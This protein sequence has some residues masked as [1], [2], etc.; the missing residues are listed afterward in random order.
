MSMVPM[1]DANAPVVNSLRALV[2]RHRAS[3]TERVGALSA[4]VLSL[5]E[6]TGPA[7]QIAMPRVGAPDRRRQRIDRF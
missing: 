1:R 4:L 2:I 5:S 3:L 6:A 7:A